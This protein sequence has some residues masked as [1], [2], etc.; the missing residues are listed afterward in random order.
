MPIYQP[1]GY[2][3]IIRVSKENPGKLIVIDCK[4]AWCGPCKAIHP[5]LVSLS[6]T[7]SHKVI[8]MEIDVDDEE[9][10][11]TVQ[12]FEVS[13]MPTFIYM[14]NGLIKA[15]TMG[16]SIKQVQDTINLFA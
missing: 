16:A 13:A 7:L 3:E 2:D 1:S 8:F 4:A 9:H 14:K 15:K 5:L 10:A 6:D 11:D 12:R